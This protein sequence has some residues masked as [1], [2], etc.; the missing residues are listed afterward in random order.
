[1]NSRS[2][3]FLLPADVV[4]FAEATL[5]IPLALAMLIADPLGRRRW[6]LS[7]M[8]EVDWYRLIPRCEEWWLVG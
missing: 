6:E 2:S 4:V 8:L 1:M 3:V 7:C 5:A